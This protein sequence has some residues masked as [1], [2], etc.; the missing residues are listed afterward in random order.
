M[1][2]GKKGVAQNISVEALK[3]LKKK[4]E[5]QLWKYSKQAMDNVMPVVRTEGKTCW[6]CQLPGTSRS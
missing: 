6:W 2:D 3:K 5:N 1:I 4:Q